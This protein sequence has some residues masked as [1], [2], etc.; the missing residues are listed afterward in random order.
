MLTDVIF[1]PERGK[2][3]LGHRE[4]CRFRGLPGIGADEFQNRWITVRIGRARIDQQVARSPSK[5]AAESG[6]RAQNGWHGIRQ[7]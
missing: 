3:G 6:P 4:M 7:K 1:T 5:S 2:T